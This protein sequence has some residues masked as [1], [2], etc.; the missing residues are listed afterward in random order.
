MEF[1]STPVVF[2]K[3][4]CLYKCSVVMGGVSV[5]SVHFD[6]TVTVSEGIYNSFFSVN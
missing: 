5:E 4:P 2:V 6:V 1:P 3:D